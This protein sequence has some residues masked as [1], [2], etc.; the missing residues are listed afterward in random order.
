MSLEALSDALLNGVDWDFTEQTV[1][2]ALYDEEDW[3]SPQQAGPSS[4]F[5]AQILCTVDPETAHLLLRQHAFTTD[6]SDP[7]L[8][9]GKMH[10]QFCSEEKVTVTS[11]KDTASTTWTMV[12]LLQVFAF[13]VSPQRSDEKRNY[14]KAKPYSRSHDGELLFVSASLAVR[15]DF[16]RKQPVIIVERFKTTEEPRK[17]VERIRLYKDTVTALYDMDCSLLLRQMSRKQ[18]NNKPGKDRIH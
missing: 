10:F 7:I 18:A 12:E 14:K 11:F 6:I 5:S 2:P 3:N 17:L 9:L 13:A 4:A 15:R 8:C 1:T 16:L